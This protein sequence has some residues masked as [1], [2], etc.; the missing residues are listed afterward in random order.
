MVET[1]ELK[2]QP[3]RLKNS[4][5]YQLLKIVFAIYFVISMFIT[6]LHMTMEYRTARELVVKELFHLQKA[7]EN[8]LSTSLYELNRDQ[9]TS[10]VAGMYNVPALV[11]IKIEASNQDI[12]IISIA[13]GTIVT[14]DKGYA[15]VDKQGKSI[16]VSASNLIEHSFPIYAPESELE[17]A[18]GTIY[19]SEEIVFSNVKAGFIRIIISAIIKTIALWILFLWAASGRLSRP[20]R[21]ITGYIAKLSPNH[22]D[23]LS[24][25]P[26]DEELELK[27]HQNEIGLLAR[28][29]EKMRS[30]ILHKIKD[31]HALE[32]VIKI[33]NRTLEERIDERTHEL[34]I[35]KEKA[36]NANRSKSAFLANMSHEL[37][38]PLNAILGFSEIIERAPDT[39]AEIQEKVAI[40]NR[41]GDHL[42]TMINDVLDIS[43]IEAGRMALEL[44]AFDLPR[45][46]QDV[47]RMFEVRAENAGIEFNQEIDPALAHFIN[48]DA[49]KLRQILI[50]L[51]GNAMKFAGESDVYL[52]ARTWPVA[53]DHTMVTL[54]LEVEDSGPGI[55]SEQLES[56][57]EP[58]VQAEGS[59][60]K[61]RGTGLGLA[62]TKSF[63]D[64]LGGKIGVDNRPG[65]GTRFHVELPVALAGA[66]ET[67]H[68]KETGRMVLGLV[69]EQPAWRILVVEDNPDNR[70]LL[71]SLLHQAGF[72]TREAENGEQA[73]TVFEQ[74]QPH[75][76]W[77]DMRMPVM[78]G[79]E[80]AAKIRSLPGGDTVKIVAITAN[81]FE[82]QRKNMLDAGCDEVVHKPLQ[83]HE[84]F[85]E[86]AQLLGAHYRYEEETAKA[87]DQAEVVSITAQ[88]LTALPPEL[89]AELEK[90]TIELDFAQSHEVVERIAT[91]EPELAYALHQLVDKFDFQ[92]IINLLSSTKTDASR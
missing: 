72:E 6:G 25:H 7:F 47:G 79:Y 60:A 52:R 19:S 5:A 66:D 56:I 91:T 78:D 86:M 32:D 18:Q 21:T 41:S 88:M 43:K 53:N 61:T 40:I 64:L 44:E 34:S 58:F 22:P 50:N 42:L 49:G 20:L 9:L 38:T 24:I 74:W 76:I 85:S 87:A 63:V 69:P 23:Y 15:E 16:Q 75:L 62:I 71:T 84:I 89:L 48:T 27:N 67:G 37:R 46:L 30:E 55:V 45:M 12:S 10:I 51:L 59:P 70:L 39:P 54:Q 2:P 29:F 92:T 13:L 73:V 11:G 77:M 3:L 57:F 4:V 1:Q 68:I 35:A 28:T 31:M 17:I 90:A 14:K 65:E 80:A 33:Q 83:A 26:T 8:G 81:A 36:E 82:E